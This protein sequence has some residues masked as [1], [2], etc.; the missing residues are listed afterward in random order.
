MLKM[1]NTNWIA[2]NLDIDI[3]K[4]LISGWLNTSEFE[5]E[6]IE[7]NHQYRFAGIEIEGELISPHIPEELSKL[8]KYYS[9][10][11]SHFILEPIIHSPEWV[12]P[13][14]QIFGSGLDHE[15]VINFCQTYNLGL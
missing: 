8:K 1:S 4:K 10:V 3:T 11:I 12:E 15:M 6:I 7:G 5:F 2:Q 14:Q 9:F 13:Y